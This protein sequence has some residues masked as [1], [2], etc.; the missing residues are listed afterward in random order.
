MAA[1]DERPVLAFRVAVKE[2]GM[3]GPFGGERCSRWHEPSHGPTAVS[4]PDRAITPAE[5]R[6]SGLRRHQV[7]CP[8]LLP[9]PTRRRSAGVTAARSNRLA[10]RAATLLVLER[11]GFR[12]GATEGRRRSSEARRSAAAARLRT[13]ATWH[14]PN[15]GTRDRHPSPIAVN[16]R[17]ITTRPHALPKSIAEQQ[18]AAGSPSRARARDTRERCRASAR[19]SGRF[20]RAGTALRLVNGFAT[21]PAPPPEIRT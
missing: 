21:P 20:A 1:K 18:R 7:V 16:P 11:G 10:A 17:F 6:R 12:S 3:S 13:T 19:T 2:G 15:E 5:L 14:C 4:P 9:S 8:I